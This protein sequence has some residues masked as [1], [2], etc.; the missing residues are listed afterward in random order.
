MKSFKSVQWIALAALATAALAAQD[1]F[2]IRRAFTVGATDT[3]K[4]E[5]EV[6]QIIEIPSMGEQDMI[7]TRIATIAVKTLAVNAEKGTADVETLTKVE[8]SAMDGSI[9]AM[10]GSQDSKLPDPKTEKGTID[11]RNRFTVAKDPKESKPAEQGGPGSMM[12]MVAGMGAVSAQQMLTLVELPEKAVKIG[13]EFAAVLPAA[14]GNAPS[15]GVKDMKMSIKL[16]GEKEVDGVKLWVVSYNGSFKLDI[17]PSKQPKKANEQASPADDVKVTG[18]GIIGGEG[19]VE[20]ATGKTI[21]NLF[22]VK[23]DLKVY[24]AQLGSELP[25]RGTVSTKLTLV[26]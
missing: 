14:A 16:V 12:S 19:L 13:D 11:S 24:V 1:P 22:T 9:A 23:N 6:K 5:S 3:Y 20:Q 18:T 15:Q 25:V 10:M 7:M 2:M 17:D 4:V 8:K 21:S 26:K